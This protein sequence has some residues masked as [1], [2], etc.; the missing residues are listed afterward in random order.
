[1]DQLSESP[2]IVSTEND[3]H[4]CPGADRIVRRKFGAV[5]KLLWGKP[6][7]EIACIAKCDPRTARRILRGEADVP[8]EVVIAANIEMLRRLS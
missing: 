5:A 3:G 7:I 2:S 4:L 6:D 8:A 1:M